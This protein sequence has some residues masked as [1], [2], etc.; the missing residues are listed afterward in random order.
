[1]LFFFHFICGGTCSC[2]KISGIVTSSGENLSIGD[3]VK[4]GDLIDASSKGS[5]VDLEIPGGGKMRLVGGVMRVKKVE[6][7]ESIYELIKG[8]IFTYL[9]PDKKSRKKT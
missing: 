9:K 1:M 5:F 6:K 8:K 2:K 4:I 7:A 3:K